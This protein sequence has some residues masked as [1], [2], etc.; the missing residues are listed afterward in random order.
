MI[1]YFISSTFRDMQSER[2]ILQNIILPDI[3]KYASLKGCDV[4]FT[5][6]RWGINT[7]DM[8]S[9][10]A[11]KK[12]LSI[13][14][15]EIDYCRPYL[16][17]LLGDRYGSLP[18]DDAMESFMQT[19]IGLTMYDDLTD[20]KSITEMEIIYGL[21]RQADQNNVI[22]C[23]RDSLPKESLGADFTSVYFEAEQKYI[24][25]LAKLKKLLIDR[26][27][28]NILRY[29][30]TWDKDTNT[31]TGLENFTQQLIERLT[32]QIDS[33]ISATVTPELAQYNSDNQ[34]CMSKCKTVVGRN[35]YLEDMRDFIQ[36]DDESLLVLTGQSGIGKSCLLAKCA[37]ENKE[38]NNVISVFCGNSPYITSAS[39][40]MYNLIYRLC[41]VLSTDSC[42]YTKDT[43]I[44]RLKE[45]LRVLIQRVTAKEKLLIFIDSLDSLQSNEDF[46]NC[47][48][49]TDTKCKIIVSTNSDIQSRILY[50]RNIRTIR[51]DEL[52]DDELSE[53]MDK[54]LSALRKE[55]PATV[56]DALLKKVAYHSPLYA[57]MVFERIFKLNQSDFCTIAKKAANTEDHEIALYSYMVSEL[58][59]L[60]ETESGLAIWMVDRCNNC[61]SFSWG[62]KV[63]EILCLFPNGLRL[64]DII[65]ILLELEDSATLLD[66]KI[67]FSYLSTMFYI[68]QNNRIRFSHR[69]ICNALTAS[70]DDRKSQIFEAAIR[71]LKKLPIEDSMKLSD[72]IRILYYCRDYEAIADYLSVLYLQQEHMKMNGKKPSDLLNSAMHALRCVFS[73]IKDEEGIE[74]INNIINSV[75]EEDTNKLY[76]LCCSFLFTFDTFFRNITFTGGADSIMKVLCDKCERVIYP[77]RYK[78]PLYLR[79]VYVCFEQSGIRA[80]KYEMQYRSFM[81]FNQYCYEMLCLIDE[82]FP[83][84][85]SVINDL[86]LSYSKVASLY[87]QRDW[88]RSLMLYDKAIETAKMP[89][90]GQ[91][92]FS[93]LHYSLH[94]ASRQKASCIIQKAI[95]NSMIGWPMDD[96]MRGL[97]DEA[98]AMLTTAIQFYEADYQSSPIAKYRN[99]SYC[100]MCLADWARANNLKTK[101]TEF[102]F[103]L[104][105]YAQMAYNEGHEILMYDLIRNAEF[106]LGYH[107]SPDDTDL[108]HLQKAFYIACKI[109]QEIPSATTQKSIYISGGRLLQI[110]AGQ[111]TEFQNEYESS[112]EINRICLTCIND[113]MPISEMLLCGEKLE[114]HYHALISILEISLKNVQ[115][116]KSLAVNAMNHDDYVTAFRKSLSAYKLL[117]AISGQIDHQRWLVLMLEICNL[118]SVCAHNARVSTYKSNTC[119]ISDQEY[120][121]T[122]QM[123]NSQFYYCILSYESLYSKDELSE[124]CRRI[125]SDCL[126]GSACAL[127]GWVFFAAENMSDKSKEKQFWEYMSK[128]GF[129]VPNQRSAYFDVIGNDELKTLAEE[130]IHIIGKYLYS[131]FH[132]QRVQRLL[133]FS[134]L[135]E[136]IALEFAYQRMDYVCAEKIIENGYDRYLELSTLYIIRKHDRKEFFKRVN[137]L[138]FICLS[139]HRKSI[140]QWRLS[141]IT[142]SLFLTEADDLFKKLL[143]QR[144]ESDPDDPRNCSARSVFKFDRR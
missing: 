18:D 17:V 118:L 15:S 43:T 141:K 14:M 93:I 5:D 96:E 114:E 69:S 100:Y 139:N 51:L 81:K 117:K 102:T 89:R 37:E 31:V 119:A 108:L 91:S 78:N 126:N 85:M 56:K 122:E 133:Y 32:R 94:S 86:S 34:Y 45:I 73:E 52:S 128:I 13:C 24:D 80:V 95:Q 26:F 6:L 2:D 112:D 123:A 61:L 77:H 57:S 36:S 10:D 124:K 49:V 38:K 137:E 60:P 12:I 65:C 16:I 30:A 7:T 97:L 99:I 113:F 71:Y 130:S 115:I 142:G 41:M 42:E 90:E 8:D 75:P 53:M 104:L 131:N 106:R 127:F 87:N 44:S 22:I 105:E 70:C 103:K 67:Y 110:Y 68:T 59:N 101:E 82:K 62:T 129:S 109:N 143:S 11:I 20:K 92:E 76:G 88:K 9:N 47:L 125:Y 50:G 107:D 54:Q 28:E 27:P 58:D 134:I 136:N 33:Q 135:F 55:L 72:Y 98:K 40:L 121:F 84:R 63:I 79:A 140:K 35:S 23:I 39:D 19:P 120:I 1:N 74:F 138:K 83:Y 29:S 144:K 48:P 4:F 66:L 64:E 46:F 3:K 21:I 25:K 111:L 116:Q 132:E